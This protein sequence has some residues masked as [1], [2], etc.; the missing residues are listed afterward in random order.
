LAAGAFAGS[1]WLIQWAWRKEAE[2][3]YR[4]RLQPGETLLIEAAPKGRAKG[5]GSATAASSAKAAKGVKA[6]KG[7][8]GSASATSAT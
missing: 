4:T 6:A 2:V 5:T 1:I 3:V 7:T 8:K